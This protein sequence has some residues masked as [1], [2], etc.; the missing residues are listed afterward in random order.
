MSSISYVMKSPVHP[1]EI[2]RRQLEALGEA[3][4]F[5]RKQMRLKAVAVAEAAGISRMTLHRIE[6]GE[7]S[8]AI[9]AYAAVVAALGVTLELIDVKEGAGPA[10]ETSAGKQAWI[11]LAIRVEDFPELQ[12][13]A[14]QVAPDKTLSPR[15]ALDIY[16]RNWRH[17]D[18]S[19]LTETERKLIANLRRV[20]TGETSV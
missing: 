10:L 13:L 15:E 8:V 16:E 9:G 11:P 1:T 4:R 2:G 3:I 19:S 18:E 7:G 20:F 17:V 14:W 6:R 12:R 5:R